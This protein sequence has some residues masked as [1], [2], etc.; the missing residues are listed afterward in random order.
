MKKFKEFR[1]KN[2]K[3]EEEL[4]KKQDILVER[5]KDEDEILDENKKFANVQQELEEKNKLMNKMKNKIRH[6]ENE[7]KDLKF[8]NEI[9]REENT[10]ALKEYYKD[11]K[12]YQ[13]VTKFILTEKEL[14]S[15]VEL[16]KW[17]EDNEEWRIQPFNFREKKINL[18]SIRPHQ[19]KYNYY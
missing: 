11:F 14:K 6:L 13:G 19:G 12:F 17:K 18:P 2:I 15:I 9:E 4:R 3:K 5:K 7:I 1:E 16:S 10:Y 8:E